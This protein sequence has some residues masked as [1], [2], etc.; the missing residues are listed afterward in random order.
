MTTPQN[1]APSPNLVRHVAKGLC[2][3]TGQDL[4]KEPNPLIQG[5]THLACSNRDKAE[6]LADTLETSFKPNQASKLT[7]EVEQEITKHYLEHSPEIEAVT[8]EECSSDEI[9]SLIKK[10][11]NGKAPGKDRITNQAIK[12][13]QNAAVNRLAEIFNTCLQ[14]LH[15]IKAWKEVRVILFHKARKPLR[16][17]AT[18]R[19]ISLLSGLSNL[20]EKVTLAHLSD[21]ASSENLLAKEHFGFWKEHSTNHQLLRVVDI[22]SHGFNINKSTG[23]VFMDVAKSFDRVWHRGLNYKLIKLK[24]SSYLVNL[25]TSYLEECTFHVAM[26]VECSTVHPI[27]AGIPQGSILGPFLFNIFT[28]Y[29]PKDLK[30]TD[31]TLYA[32]DVAVIS[33]SFNEKE[34]VKNLEA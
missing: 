24:F 17:P 23:V 29:I 9:R 18:Y 14:H 28:N 22:I 19:P 33:Q 12:M 4:R 6:V 13:F 1:L 32:D 21:F 3:N 2:I 5:K 11:K 15:F 31:L 16:D 25:L 30:K 27:L 7:V 20:F 10:L 34:V 26:C 8:I